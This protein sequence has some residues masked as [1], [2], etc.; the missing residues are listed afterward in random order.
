[1]SRQTIRIL[2]DLARLHLWSRILWRNGRSLLR[3]RLSVSDRW[4]LLLN[5]SLPLEDLRMLNTLCGQFGLLWLLLPLLGSGLLWT[6]K[7]LWSLVEGRRLLLLHLL[8]LLLMEVQISWRLEARHAEHAKLSRI[9]RW[10][11]LRH[12]WRWLRFWSLRP[13]STHRCFNLFHRH[14]PSSRRL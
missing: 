9:L 8:Y 2:K 4:W 7:D 1:M 3:R 13:L 14:R 10:W 6:L 12:D 5:R 11:H